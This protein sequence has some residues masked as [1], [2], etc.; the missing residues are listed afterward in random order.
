MWKERIKC[1]LF[2]WSIFGNPRV[3]PPLPLP[4]AIFEPHVAKY[5]A[6]STHNNKSKTHALF[7]HTR[8]IINIFCELTKE[9]FFN[10]EKLKCY[11]KMYITFIFFKEFYS[12]FFK[13]S[14]NK[15]ILDKMLCALSMSF[16]HLT[17][18][19]SSQPAGSEWRILLKERHTLYWCGSVCRNQLNYVEKV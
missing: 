4:A 19:K 18:F 14:E 10:A 1:E 9:A 3:A 6:S 16:L 11:C 5:P 13:F 17:Y 15:P 7:V 8:G 12:F 2:D